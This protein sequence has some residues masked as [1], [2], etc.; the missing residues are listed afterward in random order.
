MVGKVEELGDD[1][2]NHKILVG[3][4][5]CLPIVDETIKALKA[6]FGDN[7]D[8]EIHPCNPT[9]GSHCGP[10]GVGSCFHSKQR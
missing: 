4:T 1:V 5:D 6:K 3:H 2:A 7:L 10:N 9:A 8:I